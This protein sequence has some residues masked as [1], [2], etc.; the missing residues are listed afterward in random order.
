M[1]STR[2]PFLVQFLPLLLVLVSCH[3][4][5][6]THLEE[7]KRKKA[8]VAAAN[9]KP[10]LPSGEVSPFAQLWADYEALRSLLAADELSAVESRAQKLGESARSLSKEAE[11]SEAD[12]LKRISE[13][14]AQFR[15]Q[16]PEQL[17]A[18]FGKLSE[19]IVELTKAKAPNHFDLYHCS[20]AK[21][22]GYWIQPKGQAIA[23]PYM[24]QRMLSCGSRE[25]LR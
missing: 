15:S 2:S 21:V 4:P 20:M 3:N 24:G 8:A 16:Q 9:P 25:E 13:A 5:L 18:A 14:A 22:Y 12:K 23:N 1:R 6:K 10:V 7:Q 19:P 11:A 17:R